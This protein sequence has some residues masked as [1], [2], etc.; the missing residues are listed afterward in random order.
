MFA[1]T[2]GEEFYFISNGNILTAFLTQPFD[3]TELDWSPQLWIACHDEDEQNARLASHVWEDNGLDVSEGFLED[4]L[5][6]LGESCRYRLHGVV[7]FPLTRRS[8]GHDNA[9]VRTSSAA[10]IADAVELH[11]QTGDKTIGALQALYRE[12]VGTSFLFSITHVLMPSR[13]C[14][15]PGQDSRARI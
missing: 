11:P 15:V 6:F 10:A 2:S 8:L 4:M 12:K 13:P 1:S 5:A 3:L 14:T 7:L 9:Y